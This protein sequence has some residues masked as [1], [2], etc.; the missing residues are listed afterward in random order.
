[1]KN[2]KRRSWM[3]SSV[4]SMLLI[5]GWAVTSYGQN[6][7]QSLINAAENG[8]IAKVNT[9]LAKGVDVNAKNSIGFTA[10]R[11]A[12]QNG[13]SEVVKALLAKGADVNAKNIM[14]GLPIIGMATTFDLII[15]QAQKRLQELGYNPGSVDGISGKK[16]E[17]AIKEFQ[18]DNGLTINGQLDKETIKELGLKKEFKITLKGTVKQVWEKAK[19]GIDY[20]RI[21][22]REQGE[23]VYNLTEYQVIYNTEKKTAKVLKPYVIVT[24]ALD[25]NGKAIRNMRGKSLMVVGEKTA[26]VEEFANEEVEIIGIV[27]NTKEIEVLSVTE[28]SMSGEKAWN[29]KVLSVETSNMLGY[30]T[31]HT[32]V[33]YAPSVLG[34]DA[35]LVVTLRAN[36]VKSSAVLK[37]TKDSTYIEDEQGHKFAMK[38]NVDKK[39]NYDPD[40][41]SFSLTESGIVKLVFPISGKSKKFKLTVSN[42]FSP[43]DLPDIKTTKE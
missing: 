12:S 43:I 34:G 14:V 29:I 6:N 18:R 37:F 32:F 30:F 26:K 41:V 38:G 2:L 7:G 5:F 1:M 20:N 3:L 28:L 9:L 27:K 35:F 11:Y 4:L 23:Q 17:T 8:N 36:V 31:G 24:K 10:L 40:V 39:G 19:I 42:S 22:Y 13:H 16:T 25:E 33:T 21:D 15:Y